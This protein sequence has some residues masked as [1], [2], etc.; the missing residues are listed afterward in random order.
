[1]TTQFTRPRRTV[2]QATAAAAV[3]VTVTSS[4]FASVLTAPAPKPPAEKTKATEQKKSVDQNIA[5]LTEGLA[6]TS[7]ELK[8]SYRKLAEATSKKPAAEEAYAAAAAQAYDAAKQDA[9]L[10]SQLAA[11]VEAEN[12]AQRQLTATKNQIEST[13]EAVGRIA[14]NDYRKGGLSNSLVAALSSNNLDQMA[15]RFILV[16]TALRNQSAT[17][18]ALGQQKSAMQST[19][20]VLQARRAEVADL[21]SRSADA[22]QRAQ[23]AE[24]VAQDRKREVDELI[25]QQTQATDAIKARR[26]QEQRQLADLKARSDALAAQLRRIA[27]KERAAAAARA[28]KKKTPKNSPGKTTQQPGKP[29]TRAPRSGRVRLAKPVNGRVTSKYGMRMHPIYKYKRMHTGTDFGGG[30]GAPIRAAES[31]TVLR[32]GWAGG[33]GKQLVVN[34][35]SLKGNSFATSYSHL[36][37]FA[38]ARGQ[39]VRRGQIIGY[40]GTTGASTGCHLHFEVFRNGT[41]VNPQSYL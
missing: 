13:E 19:A 38:V 18:T 21:K 12:V 40:E 35:G 6:G 28:N 8:E 36:S 15:D 22:L 9:A 27:Q 20:D 26:A 24:D 32:S 37:R 7:A 29:S 3:L 10:A 23:V 39:K 1:M 30:C 14:A 2:F 34:H 16:D 31:G 5:E 33:Y 4:S 17:V 11:A 25:T 41:R